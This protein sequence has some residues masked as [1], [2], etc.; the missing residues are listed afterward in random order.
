MESHSAFHP[1][2]HKL[3]K[4]S[5][6]DIKSNVTTISLL[7]VAFWWPETKNRLFSSLSSWNFF[8]NLGR[9]R[10]FIC[11]HQKHFSIP[12]S[13]LFLLFWLW[14][15]QFAEWSWKRKTEECPRRMIK[16]LSHSLP[17]DRHVPNSWPLSRLLFISGQNPVLSL[18]KSN[19]HLSES[20]NRHWFVRCQFCLLIVCA[21]SPLQSIPSRS[22]A[23]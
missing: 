14:L 9:T 18:L 22:E 23:K 7:R 6:H 13:S 1:W 16:K 21:V 17:N 8:I 10:A 20:S 2:F 15:I 3:A 5:Y 12:H 4:R 11:W 19:E